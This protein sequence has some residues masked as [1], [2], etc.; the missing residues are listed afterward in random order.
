MTLTLEKRG[1]EVAA[2]ERRGTL[3][4]LSCDDPGQLNRLM[5][6]DER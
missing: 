2:L 5:G 3:P 1:V 4:H 6:A